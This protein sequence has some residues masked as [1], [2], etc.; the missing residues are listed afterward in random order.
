MLFCPPVSCGSRG[1]NRFVFPSNPLPTQ[2]HS[3]PKRWKKGKKPSRNSRAH[4]NRSGYLP[5]HCFSES[6]MVAGIA[7]KTS[8]SRNADISLFWYGKF[9]F[10]KPHVSTMHYNYYCWPGKWIVPIVGTLCHKCACDLTYWP[11]R[12]RAKRIKQGV[13]TRWGTTWVR[14]NIFLHTWYW[15]KQDWW[16]LS[17]GVF[18]HTGGKTEIFMN[19]SLTSRSSLAYWVCLI[20]IY[21]TL[22]WGSMQPICIGFTA[23]LLEW[24][25]PEEASNG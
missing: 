1:L 25:H 17:P 15:A 24:Q 6:V 5:F 23:V 2:N 7:R 19:M 22:N 9:C 14:L 12:K 11:K 16:R 3:V 21:Q 13:K 10:L 20:P 4:T 18:E 8:L